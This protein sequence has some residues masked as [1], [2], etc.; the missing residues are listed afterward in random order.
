MNRLMIA[1]FHFHHLSLMPFGSRLTACPEELSLLQPKR[2][3]GLSGLFQ[4]SLPT[5]EEPASL[6]SPSAAR[7]SG[8]GRLPAPGRLGERGQRQHPR[9]LSAAPGGAT[10]PGHRPPAPGSAVLSPRSLGPPAP[11][12]PGSSVPSPRPLPLA[13]AAPRR[14]PGAGSALRP[15]AL[16]RLTWSPPRA[17]ALPGGNSCLPHFDIGPDESLRAGGS[18]TCLSA[19]AGELSCW[20]P[21]GAPSFVSW[22]RERLLQLCRTHKTLMERRLIF[23]AFSSEHQGTAPF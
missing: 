16:S 1:C 17:F 18:G 22:G 3:L 19:S 8:G 20:G 9:G 21:P 5:P 15:A 7:G 2:S 11:R 4:R 6:L 14:R 13:F 10:G 23:P 12:S